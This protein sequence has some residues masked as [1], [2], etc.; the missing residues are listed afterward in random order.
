[1]VKSQGIHMRFM[2]VPKSKVL[3]TACAPLFIEIHFDQDSQDV[4]EQDAQPLRDSQDLVTSALPQSNAEYKCDCMGDRKNACV[5]GCQVKAE[6]HQDHDKNTGDRL[7]QAPDS[8][9]GGR[10][11]LSSGPTPM[12]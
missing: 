7:G 8:R 10:L 9:V 1:M 12:T 3:E 4:K 11:Q 5:D 2:D 6:E